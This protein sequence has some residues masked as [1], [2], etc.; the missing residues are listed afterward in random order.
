MTDTVNDFLSQG[1]YTKRDPLEFAIGDEHTLDIIETPRVVE[2]KDT[3]A[4]S[5]KATKLVIDARTADGERSLWVK[6]G[7][8]L[9]RAIAE[10]AKETG[11]AVGGKLRIKRIEDAEPTKPGYKGAHQF[12]AQYTAPVAEPVS[13]DS[14]D[15]GD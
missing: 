6:A 9:Q 4:D 8:G 14:D 7:S 13:A 1:D 12:R 2:V 5:G 15:W 3:F 11:L 10:A